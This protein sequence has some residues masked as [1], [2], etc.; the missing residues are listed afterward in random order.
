MLTR[1]RMARS[2]KRRKTESDIGS[3]K[4]SSEEVIKKLEVELEEAKKREE[5]L[6]SENTTLKAEN[7][8]LKRKEEKQQKQLESIQSQKRRVESQG[9]HLE[10]KSDNMGLL[11]EELLSIAQQYNQVKIGDSF[12]FTDKLSEITHLLLQLMATIQ[13]LDHP[14]QTIFTDRVVVS[15]RIIRTP[16]FGDPTRATASFLLK[17]LKKG[18]V[19]KIMKDSIRILQENNAD[20]LSKL[21]V[22]LSLINRLL[23][24]KS[25]REGY[26]QNK[27]NFIEDTEKLLNYLLDIDPDRILLPES[28]SDEISEI[29]KILLIGENEKDYLRMRK[30]TDER[31]HNLDDFLNDLAIVIKYSE[32]SC[33][34]KYNLLSGKNIS[35]TLLNR[36]IFKLTFSF[37]ICCWRWKYGRKT[38]E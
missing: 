13:M 3:S 38:S 16:D 37:L 15:G 14:L 10:R 4:L 28:V 19:P 8:I 29:V 5:I 23:R 20:A 22:P 36:S 18:L 9:N 6:K 12:I 7:E 17:N 11:V 26:S 27:N 34:L 30:F 32:V 21:S 31:Y 24:F 33:K 1:F 35:A 25:I 2:Q